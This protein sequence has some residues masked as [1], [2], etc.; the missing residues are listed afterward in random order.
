MTVEQKKLYSELE[1]RH[2]NIIKNLNEQCNANFDVIFFF[3]SN[4]G[5]KQDESEKMG[6]ILGSYKRI[7]PGSVMI[8]SFDYNLDLKS[9]D[10][11]E[12][13]YSIEDAPRIVINEEDSFYLTNIDDL[14]NYLVS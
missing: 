2:F 9:I 10:D 12:L 7:N 14:D 3:Y 6:F 1:L 13:E 8:Y 4:A 11:L 5:N